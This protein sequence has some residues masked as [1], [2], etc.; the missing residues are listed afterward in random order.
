MSWGVMLVFPSS[1]SW[2]GGSLQI[3]FLNW[4]HNCWGWAGLQKRRRVK[5]RCFNYASVCMVVASS[6]QICHSPSSSNRPHL[7]QASWKVDI[8]RHSF[9]PTSPQS[10]PPSPPLPSVSPSVW[11]SSPV[12]S[13]TLERA[14]LRPRPVVTSSKTLK[15]QTKPV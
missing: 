3:G 4:S 11:K 15:D 5:K 14:G 12:Q 9:S 6:R 7:R 2:Y 13:L 1:W 8:R 10:I